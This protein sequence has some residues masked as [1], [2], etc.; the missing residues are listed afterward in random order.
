MNRFQFVADHADA[1][2]VKRLCRVL[3][4]ARSSFYRWRSAAASRAARARAETELVARI[5][6]DRK[7]VV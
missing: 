3:G 1:F 7:S 2:G 6:V 4:V 5:R